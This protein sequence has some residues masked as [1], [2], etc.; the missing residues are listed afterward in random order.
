MW[1]WLVE[2]TMIW[3]PWCTVLI[4]GKH[5]DLSLNPAFKQLYRLC[6]SSTAEVYQSLLFSLWGRHGGHSSGFS[7]GI[8]FVTLWLAEAARMLGS[9]EP[10]VWSKRGKTHHSVI[11]CFSGDYFVCLFFVIGSRV[12]DAKYNVYDNGIAKCERLDKH[13]PLVTKRV[14][15]SMSA[16]WMTQDIKQAKQPRRSAERQ[17]HKTSLEVHRQIYAHWCNVVNRLIRNAKKQLL[18]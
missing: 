6:P 16:P 14:T 18:C 11:Q 5:D 10:W 15:D 17:W 1:H 13:A 8:L 9:L 12:G 3:P 4:G 2:C 7:R